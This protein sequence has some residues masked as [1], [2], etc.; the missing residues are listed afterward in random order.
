VHRCRRQSCSHTHFETVSR[1]GAFAVLP[2]RHRGVPDSAGASARQRP[3]RPHES[4][5]RSSAYQLTLS[6]QR[7]VATCSRCMCGTGPRLHAEEE[8]TGAGCRR[9]ALVW[10]DVPAAA[11]LPASAS[12]P[13]P[14][15]ACGNRLLLPNRSSLSD[16]RGLSR[17]RS[18]DCASSGR[19]ISPA[20]VP[21]ARQLPTNG[22]V[23]GSAVRA[24]PSS[25]I[26]MIMSH[27]PGERQAEIPVNREQ[28][29]GE[30]PLHSPVDSERSF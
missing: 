20:G 9:R 10:R 13:L 8:R 15:A 5:R 28:G 2:N 7:F 29:N 12:E 30:V 3:S 6:L 14:A 26:S 21:P 23:P 24:A 19:P 11:K 4:P 1:R 22:S 17:D 27:I 16:G 25:W 18:G